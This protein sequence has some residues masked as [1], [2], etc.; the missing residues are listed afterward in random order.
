MCSR[1]F[2]PVK[3]QTSAVNTAYTRQHHLLFLYRSEW[4]IMTIDIE[5]IY[6]NQ[7]SPMGLWMV[8]QL[9]LRDWGGTGACPFDLIEYCYNPCPPCPAHCPHPPANHC[10]LQG[11]HLLTYILLDI[12][13]YFSRL[14]N[15][16]RIFKF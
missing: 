8:S 9:P 3:H 10:R 12:Y 5:G 2:D 7:Y 1:Y 15:H 6:R 11:D 16:Q 13:L 14:G 4:P